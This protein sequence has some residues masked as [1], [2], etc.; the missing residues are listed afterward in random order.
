V[1]NGF[2]VYFLD[3]FRST[4]ELSF[5]VR[6]KRCACGIMVT[7]SHNPPS[8]NAV[9]AYWSTGGQLLPP[10][11]QGVIQ[12]VMA[13]GEIGRVPFADALACGSVVYCQQEVDVEYQR[14][15]QA[16][17]RPGPRKLK[18]IY[19]PMHG[20]GATSVCPVLAAVGFDE[21]EV[22]SP[23][24]EPNGDFPNVP[25]HVANPENPA[26][27]DSIIAR[28]KQTGADLIL[29]TD[30]DADRLGCAAAVTTGGEWRTFTGNQ[31]GCLLA[32]SLLE[33]RK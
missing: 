30:P 23:H 26:T 5:A 31:I 2:K 8:D 21:V 29:S 7:A 3:G 11:D 20:V 6:H 1:A 9:K 27:F 19:S 33:G 4:P 17:S 18:I 28:A 25:D 32:E 22:F 14:C 12:R 15:V 13:A 10:H 16:Q 24:A